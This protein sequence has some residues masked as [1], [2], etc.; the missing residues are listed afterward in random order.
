MCMSVCLFVCLSACL[1][2]R[3]PTRFFYMYVRKTD[4]QRNF[5]ARH[6][7]CLQQPEGTGPIR[8]RHVRSVCPE[9]KQ[10]YTHSRISHCLDICTTKG[11][12]LKKIC[13]RQRR[14]DIQ[15][16]TQID[17]GR[18]RVERERKKRQTDREPKKDFFQEQVSQVTYRL[19]SSGKRC[20]RTRLKWQR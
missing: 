3:L 5:L 2:A 4:R 1:C 6:S 9:A 11:K 18:E 14:T 10:V 17:R 15:T 8:V 7:P 13:K 20:G 19:P 16:H 12:P